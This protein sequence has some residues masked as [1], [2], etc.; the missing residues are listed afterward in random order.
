MWDRLIGA[1]GPASILVVLRSRMSDAMLRRYTPEDVW[2]ETLLHAWRDRRRC[3]WRGVAAFRHWLLAISKNRIR[4]LAEYDGAGKRQGDRDALVF[5]GFK[6]GASNTG[7]QFAGPV[8]TTTPSRVASDRERADRMQTALDS[9]PEDLRDVVRLRLFEDLP[10]EEV[11]EE[12]G[13]GVSGVR[14]RFR[15][16]ATL[17]HQRLADA[18]RTR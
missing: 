18:L 2:Q 5:S 7:S 17:Y 3:E 12:V 16:G 9:L 1:V 15:R 8:A 6:G 14:H 13:V 11:A 10:L 4:A